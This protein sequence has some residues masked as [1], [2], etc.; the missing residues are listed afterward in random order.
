MSDEFKVKKYSE[1][2]KRQ[3]VEEYESG[4]SMNYL[5]R[6]YKIGGSMTIHKWI[7]KYS[8]LGIRNGERF[9]KEPKDNQDQETVEK[10]KKK[11]EL[12]EKAV[13]D[14]TL[15]KLI[16]ESTLEEYQEAYGAL[17]SKKNGPRLLRGR[18]EKRKGK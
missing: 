4:A 7:R 16:L 1:A 18:T 11:I 9:M 15:K 13:A 2:F 17:L 12:L 10:L 8:N 5:R 14:L 3:V 6:K